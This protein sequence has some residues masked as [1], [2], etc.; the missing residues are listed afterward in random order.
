MAGSRASTC[1]ESRSAPAINPA[2][3]GNAGFNKTG[4]GALQFAGTAANTYNQTSYVW[5]GSLELNKTAAIDAIPNVALVVGDE[6]GGTLA[7]QLLLLAN[8]QINDA[9]AITLRGTG[10]FDL[11][12]A[13]AGNFSDATGAGAAPH[14]S[15]CTAR[16]P[17]LPAGR[18]ERRRDGSCEVRSADEPWS[19]G[20]FDTALLW[21]QNS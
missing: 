4:A 11:T 3:S 10:V 20:D 16:G 13:G 9:T 19:A 18:P 17:C 21:G 14:C 5:Q 12:N 1:A 2:A 7:D 8:N 6:V 15:R